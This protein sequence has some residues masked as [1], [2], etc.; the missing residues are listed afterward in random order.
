[1]SSFGFLYWL[2]VLVQ[3]FRARLPLNHRMDLRKCEYHKDMTPREAG[4]T[5]LPT[6][7]LCREAVGRKQLLPQERQAWFFILFNRDTPI[8]P[9]RLTGVCG[10]PAPR[11]A[12]APAI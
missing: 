11:S 2:S 6:Y 5:P 10:Q 8:E 4:A 12:F 7:V 1:M 9:L 3:N